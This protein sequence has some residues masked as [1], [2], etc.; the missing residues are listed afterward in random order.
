MPSLIN[1]NKPTLINA[2]PIW[3]SCAPVFVRPN[4]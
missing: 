1:A 4:H 2:P 3:G